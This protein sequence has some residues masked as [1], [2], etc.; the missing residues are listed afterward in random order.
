MGDSRE[1]QNLLIDLGHKAEGD[2][3][4]PYS[5]SGFWLEQNSSYCLSQ[6]SLPPHR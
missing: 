4:V 1:S 6:L 2:L 3:R 5:P